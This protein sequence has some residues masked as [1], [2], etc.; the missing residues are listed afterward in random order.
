[1]LNSCHR[2][3][4]KRWNR[5]GNHV[6]DESHISHSRRTRQ[7]YTMHCAHVSS[8]PSTKV[9]RASDSFL[10]TS[11]AHRSTTDST[12]ANT[13]GQVEPL[14]GAGSPISNLS[15]MLHK[16]RKSFCS[17][18]CTVSPDAT[19]LSPS[20]ISSSTLPTSWPMLE[21][22][23]PD[24]QHPSNARISRWLRS[25]VSHRTQRTSCAGTPVECVH[26][27]KS[28][29]SEL[30]KCRSPG[31]CPSASVCAAQTPPCL[32]LCQ[33]RYAVAAAPLRQW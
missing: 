13:S 23:R 26:R 9:G 3:R 19:L 7:V 16:Q 11:E 24:A 5:R 8:K 29:G 17:I 30:F 15:K 1:M 21:T 31:L 22:P 28:V 18:S 27:P 6:S 4:E 25:G 12:D 33:R 14:G 2:R 10:H 20:P 32:R